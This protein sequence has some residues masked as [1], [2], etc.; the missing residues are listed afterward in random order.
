M[1]LKIRI[2]REQEVFDK[3][4]KIGEDLK[5]TAEALRQ[6]IN[7]LL[8]K[9]DDMKN[10]SLIKIKSLNEKI[11]MTREELL[12]VIYSEAFLPDFKEAI[13]MLTQD[14][15]RASASAKDAGRALTARRVDEKCLTTL[16]ESLLSYISIILEASD[17]VVLM[18]SLL[19]KDIASALKVGKEV[20]MLER[21]GDEIKDMIITRL[22]DMEDS[23]H[24]ITLL[25]TRDAIFFLDDILDRMESAVLSIEI[26]Y[27]ILKS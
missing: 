2:N 26:L 27:A 8:V 17:K 13:V 21:S 14:L 15:Y 23:L 7:A 19:P 25:Q 18:L 24:L 9:D 1:V 6:L 22:Y 10:S 20:Q 4:I 12:S 11:S 3:L 16:K 5:T